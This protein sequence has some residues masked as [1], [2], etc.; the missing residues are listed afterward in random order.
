MKIG[1]GICAH[2]EEAGIIS[3]VTSVVTS[4]QSVAYPLDWELIVC[5]NG[6]IDRTPELIRS[7]LS[8]NRGLPVSLILLD[9]ANLVEAQRLIAT[10]L[11]ERHSDMLAFFDADIVVDVGC[12]PALLRA[13]SA[14]SIKAAYATSVPISNVR[15]TIIEKTLNQYDSSNTIF[16]KRKH[17]HGRAFLIKEWSIPAT[18]HQLL[19]DDIYLSCDLLYRFGP[20]AIVASPDALVYFHQISSIADFYRAYKR[21]TTELAKC[22]RLF[23]H[24]KSLPPEQINRRL[25]LSQLLNKSLSQSY[26]WIIFLLLRKYFRLKLLIESSLADQPSTKWDITKTTK[27]TFKWF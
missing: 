23:P 24:F 15:P 5:A 22:L 7:W 2:N 27:K 26:Y 10:R 13:A 12:I 3:T 21:R 25:H 9:P 14:D 17:L 18:T 4:V 6:C 1:I 20:H 11:K 16:S 19:A 8:D